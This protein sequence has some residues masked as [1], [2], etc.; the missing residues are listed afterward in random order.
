MPTIVVFFLIFGAL[1][2]SHEFGHFI[3]ARRVGMRVDEFGFGFPPKLFSWKRRGT[4]YTV[5]AIPFGGFVRIFGEDDAAP[6]AGSDQ[7][8]FGA[9]PLRSQ[10]LVIVAGV[11]FNLGLAWAL[12]SLGFA[13]GT[14]AGLEEKYAAYM[15][16]IKIIVSDVGIGTPAAGAGIQ[17]G[18]S[19]L[20]IG[21]GSERIVSADAPDTVA[22]ANFIGAGGG[23]EILLT[24]ER[25]AEEIEVRV[26]PRADIAPGRFAIGITL[27]SVGTVKLPI[28]LAIWEGLRRTVRF[29][30]LTLAAIGGLIY[31]ALTGGADLS[32]LAGPIG[33]YTIVGEASGLGFSYLLNL[34]A[35]L[36]ISIALINVLPFPALDGGRLLFLGIEALRGAPL[37]PRFVKISNLFGF[38]LLLLV[39]VLISYHDLLRLGFLGS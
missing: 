24:L 10:A 13:A 3:T 30:Y 26:A 20:S 15:S 27:D 31:G 16:D 23:K 39:M 21:R 37:A 8:A 18:D 9:F 22:V 7:R 2:L 5:N 1:I 25:G 33:I 4:E 35:L 28:H 29:S 17:S 12:L 14:P 11:L 19:I 6:D 38:A 34:T 32:T 36:S